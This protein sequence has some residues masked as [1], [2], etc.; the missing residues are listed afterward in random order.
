MTNAPDD[1]RAHPAERLAEA[2][3]ELCLE[4]GL[5]ALSAR[6]LADHSGFAPS[7]M[8]YQFGGRARLV[9]EVQSRTLAALE[10]WRAG[11][12][13]ALSAPQPAWLSTSAW[14]TARIEHL[15]ASRRTH[16]ALQW[17]LEA[18][19]ELGDDVLRKAAADEI[20]DMHRFWVEGAR[21]TGAE[22]AAAEAWANLAEGLASALTPEPEPHRRLSWVFDAAV[23][24][25]ARLRGREVG[26]PVA[27]GL[28][29]GSRLAQAPEAEGARKIL[30]AALRVVAEKG[31]DRLTQRDVATAA[32]VSLAATT[33]FFRTKSELL[34]AA[35][36]ELHRRV[37][38]QVLE[39]FAQG[40]EGLSPPGIVDADSPIAWSVRAMEALHRAAAR[41]PGL[42][43]LARDLL[44]TRGATSLPI[45]HGHGAASADALDAFIWSTSMS[46]VL[47]RLWVL[48][49]GDRAEALRAA[50]RQQLRVIFGVEA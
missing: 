29:A 1:S 40:E 24:L 4:R 27:P 48:P 11:Q 42:Q 28:D 20:A 50:G 36:N 21:R 37:R 16:L 14:A 6:S 35:F 31:V 38:A 10:A 3:L 47:R 18:E 46:A 22:P 13:D 49:A 44:S 33:Y 9:R 8:T 25:D 26:P 7:A 23:R 41:D 12:S 2:A 15:L 39:D 34:H 17:E 5:G 19:G 30:D 43:L 32:G 45:L